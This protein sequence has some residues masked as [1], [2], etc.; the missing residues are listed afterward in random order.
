MSLDVSS[1]KI[2]FNDRYG[3]VYDKEGSHRA[4]DDIQES[5]AELKHYLG[6]VQA[7]SALKPTK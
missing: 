1:F 6:F 4:L 7:P 5:I 3:I 2:V